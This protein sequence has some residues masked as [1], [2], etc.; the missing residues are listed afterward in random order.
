MQNITSILITLVIFFYICETEISFNPFSI[1]VKSWLSGI[2]F[3]VLTTGVFLTVYVIEQ[4]AMM[5]GHIK[6][7]ELVEEMQKTELDSKSFYKSR[8]DS[9]EEQIIRKEVLEEYE[10]QLKN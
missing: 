3:V 1:E 5:K 7:L 2:A 4:K 9:I 6:C 10:Q 8:L